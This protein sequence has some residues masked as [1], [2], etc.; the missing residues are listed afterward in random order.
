MDG[1]THYRIAIACKPLVPSFG[2]VVRSNDSTRRCLACKFI[3]C[4]SVQIAHSVYAADSSF[5]SFLL[6]K[7]INGTVMCAN[8][9][10]DAVFSPVGVW[11]LVTAERAAYNAPAFATPIRRTRQMLL[12]ALADK[13]VQLAK[14]KHISATNES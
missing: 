7:L 10:R 3:W 9:S 4:F 6:A 13:L 2:P 8:S 14:N 1:R 12:D 5:R 11:V